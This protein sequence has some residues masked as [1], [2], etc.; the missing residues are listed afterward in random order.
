[1]YIVSIVSF[2]SF[3]IHRYNVPL[4][5]PDQA[6]RKSTRTQLGEDSEFPAEHINIGTRSDS[7]QT[8][9]E[10][11]IIDEL[12]FPITNVLALW[13]TTSVTLAKG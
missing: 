3:Y 2:Y 11:K 6:S 7:K 1:M 10:I 9:T 12:S 8:M 5:R 4:G 13:D